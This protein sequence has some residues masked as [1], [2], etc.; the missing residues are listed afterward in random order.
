VVQLVQ[1]FTL[2]T[3]TNAP[4]ATVPP[5]GT[6]IYSL[7]IGPT[8]G[9]V[10]PA[11]VTLSVSGLPP[12]ATATLSPQ[13]L[14][15]G[16]SLSPITLTIQ[17]PQSTAELHRDLRL[18]SSALALLFLP[19][20]RRMRRSRNTLQ[21]VSFVLLLL[22]AGASATVGLTGCEVKDSG[23][24]AQSEKTYVVPITATS[25]SLSHSTSVTLTVE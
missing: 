9:T 5:G 2:S 3:P 1:D 11:P 10:F 13:T 20:A 19:F 24:F 22:I 12:G 18:A 6:A 23:F 4:S 8:V 21:R 15:A 16:L 25:G 14:P 7:S 17:V